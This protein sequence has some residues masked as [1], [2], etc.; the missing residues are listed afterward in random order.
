ME[1]YEKLDSS[2]RARTLWESGAKNVAICPCKLR[3]GR[4]FRCDMILGQ[5]GDDKARGFKRIVA[6]FEYYNCTT[7]D[8]GYYAAFY[9]V[10]NR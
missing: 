5:T 7:K 6:D 4:P 8:A 10:H 2:H 9:L 1:R 3:P